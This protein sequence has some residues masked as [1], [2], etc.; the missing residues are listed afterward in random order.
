MT[1]LRNLSI[2]LRLSFLIS[3]MLLLALIV[4]LSG[5]Y[6]MKSANGTIDKLY[7]QH[8]AEMQR[9]VVILEKAEAI[10]SQ[11]ML[12][13]QHSTSSPFAAMHDH[14]LTLHLD[15]IKQDQEQ[16]DVNWKAFKSS[17]LDAEQEQLVSELAKTLEVFAQEGVAAVLQQLQKGYYYDASFVVLE[18]IN[19]AI[20]KIRDTINQ[21][22][23]MQKGGAGELFETMETKYHFMFQLVIV[24]LAAGALVSL[25][26]AYFTIA[27]ISHSVR[28][29]E[30][31][32]TQLADGKLSVRIDDKSRDEFGRIAHAFN[33]MA[34]KF[35][36]TINEVKDSVAQLAAAAEETSVVT[37]QTTT[38]INQQLA[39]TSQVATAVNQ[40]SGTVQEVANNANDAA[41][42]AKQAD[43]TFEDGKQVIDGVIKAIGDLAGEVESTATVIQ[44]L[45]EES[46]GIGTVLDVIKGIAEQTN[47]LALNAAIEAA[48][49]GEQGR[50]FAVVADEVRTLAGRTQNATREIEEMISK[51]QAGTASAVKVMQN[52]KE[53]TQVGVDQAASAGEAL[54]TINEAVAKISGMNVQ[55]AKAATEQNSVTE[56]IN[57]SIV[58]INQVAEQSAA[59]AQQTAA[60]SG[61]LSKLAGQLKLLVDRFQV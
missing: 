59:G 10:R 28:E 33:Q 41:D 22:L 52:G 20:H 40:M 56:E 34:V 57:R 61:D 18:N 48:R 6:G 51:L 16:I 32:A 42:A 2:T 9:L 21:L 8:M 50:G 37:S 5:L 36:E 49:A 7:N 25:V 11:S 29:V 15:R 1:F 39:E 3:L 35:R 31:A 45:E 46:Q 27:G 4:G 12:A 53:M 38:G 55:I 26:L 43:Q 13:L 47:L 30:Q 60:A 19:P 44:Q 14:P 17:S 23:A 24:S 58:N 54:K